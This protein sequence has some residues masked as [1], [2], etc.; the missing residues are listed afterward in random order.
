MKNDNQENTKIER[1]DFRMFH[2]LQYDRIEK[3]ELGRDNF[4]N[5]IV[6]ITSGIFLIGFSDLSKLNEITG[7]LIPIIVIFINYAAITYINKSREFKLMHKQRA[8]EARENYAKELQDINDK[9]YESMKVT[10]KKTR[11][12]RGQ[13]FKTLHYI[14]IFSAIF[15]I[16][17]YWV[18]L[19]NKQKEP[20]QI[21]IKE[22]LNIGVKNNQTVDYTKPKK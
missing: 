2:Q 18:S 14:I 4:S 13:I 21:E 8:K 7:T 9:V 19:K 5:F 6:T 15:M 10:E 20:L 1:E 22:P 17:Y 3:I 16:G 12:R 11:F